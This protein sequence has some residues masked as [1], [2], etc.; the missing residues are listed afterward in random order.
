VVDQAELLANRRA[1]LQDI[2]AFL[3]VEPL[4]SSARFDEELFKSSE[5]RTYPASYAYIVEHVIARP[6]QWLPVRVRQSARGSVERL[7]WPRLDK[8][9]LD[10]VTRVRLQN[11]YAGEI[12]RLRALTGKTFPSW[13]V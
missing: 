2:F 1:A 6:L 13:S 12:G 5:R 4:F 10:D 7:L 11:L 3:S 8:P 9:M